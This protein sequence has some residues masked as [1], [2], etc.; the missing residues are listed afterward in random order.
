M[1][2]LNDSDAQYAIARRLLEENRD[3]V[4]V[5]TNGLVGMGND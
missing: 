1:L 4:E 5:M 2:K 3:K